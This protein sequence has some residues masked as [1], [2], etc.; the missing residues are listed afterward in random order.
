[1]S[2]TSNGDSGETTLEGDQVI[3]VNAW[4]TGGDTPDD[5]GSGGSFGLSGLLAVFGLGAYRQ[6]KSKSNG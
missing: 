4:N 3:H 5:G 6:R 2:V 1:M